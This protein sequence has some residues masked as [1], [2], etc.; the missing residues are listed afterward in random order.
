M[1]Y[2]DIDALIELEPALLMTNAALFSQY[3]EVEAS[4]ALALTADELACEN[5]YLVPG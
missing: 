5:L 3:N 2:T 1:E 4:P